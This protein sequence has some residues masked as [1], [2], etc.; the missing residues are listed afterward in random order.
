M[1]KL[2][3]S[4]FFASHVL[5]NLLGSGFQ[6]HHFF[7]KVTYGLCF[8]NPRSILSLYLLSTL[9]VTLLFLGKN[10]HIFS[11][12]S[13]PLGFPLIILN[14]SFQSLLQTSQISVLSMLKCPFNAVFH[15]ILLALYS[16]LLADITYF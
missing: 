6:P 5:L 14:I 4:I 3:V 1:Y 11:R 2:Y 15:T 8:A 7:V 12:I 9:M 10:F 13:N 16:Y